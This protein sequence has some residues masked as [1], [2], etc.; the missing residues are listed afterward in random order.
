[1]NQFWYGFV[2][3]VAIYLAIGWIIGNI[4]IACH[5][6]RYFADGWRWDWMFRTIA[7]ATAF[8]PSL[9]FEWYDEVRAMRAAGRAAEGFGI[10]LPGDDLENSAAAVVAGLDTAPATIW[11]GALPD[12]RFILTAGAWPRHECQRKYALDRGDTD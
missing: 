11:Y 10:D 4:F 3:A 12:G 7:Y 8:G 9:A 5:L 1:M 6:A 2:S